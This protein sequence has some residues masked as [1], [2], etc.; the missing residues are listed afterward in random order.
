[1]RFYVSR[2]SHM[3]GG[4]VEHG[5]RAPVEGAVFSPDDV[6]LNAW[7]V[8]IGTLDDLLRMAK[9]QGGEIIVSEPA[10]DLP[11]IEIYDDY[12]E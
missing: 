11:E 5:S 10:G 9:E 6:H 2:T 4:A 8:E 12:R 1:M 3:K 7:V